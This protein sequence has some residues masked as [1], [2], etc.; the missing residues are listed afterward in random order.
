MF[1]TI[2]NFE[3]RHNVIKKIRRLSATNETEP[4]TSSSGVGTTEIK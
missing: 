1:L 4:T 3:I 2:I